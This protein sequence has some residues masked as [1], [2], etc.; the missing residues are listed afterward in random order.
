MSRFLIASSLVILVLLGMGGSRSVGDEVNA[1]PITPQGEFVIFAWN[2]LGMHCLNPT[3]DSAVV[4]PPYNTVWAQVIRSGDRPQVV[5]DGITVQ[6]R[7]INNTYSYGKTHGQSKYGEFWDNCLALFGVSLA[8]DTGL[9]LV[10]PEIH[11]GLSGTMVAKGDHFE[12]DGIP[13]TPVDDSLAWNPYQ[14]VEVTARDS[15]NNLIA[16]TRTTAPTSDEMNCSKC[17]GPSG[18]ADALAKHDAR[19]GTT[20]SANKPVLCAGCHGSPALGQSG[21]G[22]SGKYLSQAMHGFHADKGAG[23]YDCHPGLTTQ[24]S[25]SLKHSGTDGKGNCITCHGTMATVASSITS[26]RVP[27][28]SEPK[29]VACHGGVAQVDTGATLY[30]NA[31][32]SHGSLYCAACHSSPHAMTPTSQASDSYQAVQYQSRAKTIGSCG[33][34]HAS[35][36]GEEEDIGEFSETHGGSN[37]ETRTACNVCHTSVSADT[38]KWPHAYQWKNHPRTSTVGDA[39]GRTSYDV[40]AQ[41]QLGVDLNITN[42]RGDALSAIKAEWLVFTGTVGGG[43]LPIFVL[44]SGGQILNVSQVRD[45]NAVTYGYNH[46]PDVARIVTLAPGSLGM[47]P[48]DTLMYG[49]AYTTSDVSRFVLDNTV[50]LNVK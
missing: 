40:R 27:W 32:D 17:H 6:Y 49:Y 21:P 1:V 16:Q 48:G 35:S 7:L 42:G 45:F 41:E 36:R 29:C 11:N 46:G 18:F 43:Q 12:V 37:P 19:E 31:K 30:R 47:G 44:T 15:A 33:V 22:S 14:V 2:D 50:T 20:L 4:L 5:T 8:H 24:C 3:Y 28:Q 23:C 13:L 34:C 39:P 9:N 38:A 26:G 25:R 10:D